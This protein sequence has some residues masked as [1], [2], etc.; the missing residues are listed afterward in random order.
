MHYSEFDFTDEPV[1]ELDTKDIIN[2][3]LLCQIRLKEYT[4]AAIEGCPND[5]HVATEG[6]RMHTQLMRT[7]MWRFP[8]IDDL[9]TSY[10]PPPPH[11]PQVSTC[12]SSSISLW[13]RICNMICDIKT[14]VMTRMDMIAD[15]SR[16]QYE[17]LERLS[18]EVGEIRDHLGM[19][20]PDSSTA[21]PSEVADDTTSQDDYLFPF[22]FEHFLF[23]FM[24]SNFGLY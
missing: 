2:V 13:S 24:F 16:E 11:P 7:L 6:Q 5:G 3:K 22:Y 14:R 9:A 18:R 15:R 17:Q 23:I 8:L 21:G 10:L 4:I 19:R 1:V 12:A 20:P